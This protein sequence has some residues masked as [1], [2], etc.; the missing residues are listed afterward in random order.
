MF[1]LFGTGLATTRRQQKSRPRGRLFLLLRVGQ[2]A[3]Y[4]LVL[5]IWRTNPTIK[6]TSAKSNRVK[7]TIRCTF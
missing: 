3:F 7:H 4:S 2:K 5:L 1:E 6:N